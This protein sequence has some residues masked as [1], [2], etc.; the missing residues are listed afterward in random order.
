MK[1]ISVVNQKGGVGKTTSVINISSKLSEQYKVLVVDLDQ[2]AN[3]TGNC[4]YDEDELELTLYNLLSDKEVKAED[5]I[6]KTSKGFDLIA[7]SIELANITTILAN[8]PNR[9]RI[10][11]KKFKP[12]MDLYDYILLDCGPSFDITTMNALAM[13]DLALIPM[14]AHKF[15][16]KG[17][18]NILEFLDIIK[19]EFEKANKQ[20][21]LGEEPKEFTTDI[22]FK[23]F[24]IDSTNFKEWETSYDYLEKSIK[25][26]AKGEYTTYKTDRTELDLVYEIMLKQNFV[27]TEKLDIINTSEG[28]IYKIANGITYIFLNKVT[29]SV[30][31]KI[32][33]L[34]KEVQ[35]EYGLE[36]PTV[37]L[38]EAYIDTGIKTNAIQNFKSNGITN[39]ITV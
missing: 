27:L 13:S 12:I 16:V 19:E 36:N 5:C 37:I 7:G 18:K 10:M 21:E 8:S 34:K 20:L 17:I 3:A 24:K 14:E 1:I 29:T 23:V 30:V 11:A 35:A 26:S 9:E 28:N 22:G 39:I 6:I 31:D 38:N 2:Q 32:I 33:D 4:G 15:S 25:Q